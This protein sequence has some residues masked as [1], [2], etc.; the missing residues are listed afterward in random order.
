M[1]K[2]QSEILK[3]PYTFLDTKKNALELAK[4]DDL[5]NQ[6]ASEGWELVAQSFT[7]LEDIT[8][9]GILLTFRIDE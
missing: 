8:S 7:G 3:I 6:R 2:Y 1:Y 9:T 4:F 5:I